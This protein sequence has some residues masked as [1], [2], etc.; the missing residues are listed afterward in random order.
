MKKLPLL[1]LAALCG[2]AAQAAILS[3][4]VTGPNAAP[5]GGATVT[6]FSEDGLRKESVYTAD[7]G[8]YAIVTDFGGKLKLRS[9]IAGL[10]DSLSEAS[11]GR[12]EAV[13]FDF[14]MKPHASAAEASDALPASSMASNSSAT[15]RSRT[16]SGRSPR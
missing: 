10:A 6:V 7:D 2:G 4:Q 15:A 12:S 8:S 11:V 13:R 9:R 5:V 1:V 3:G 16:A 14:A